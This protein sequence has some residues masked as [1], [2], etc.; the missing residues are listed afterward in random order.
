M[1]L[2]D[3]SSLLVTLTRQKIPTIPITHFETT[4]NAS[5]LN[6]SVVGYMAAI[7]QKH[8]IHKQKLTE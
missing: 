4:V 5:L 8:E 6:S 7:L 3:L 1:E 2:D